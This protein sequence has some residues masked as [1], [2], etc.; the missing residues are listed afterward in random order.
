MNCISHG[1]YKLLLRLHPV[2][3]RIQFAD[4]MMKLHG[5]QSQE[6]LIGA[7]APRGVSHPVRGR[8]DARLPG[9]YA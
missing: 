7:V 4:E 2:E 8:D 9:G 6:Q 5:V 1:A 3:F